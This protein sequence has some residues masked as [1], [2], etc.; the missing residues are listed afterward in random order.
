MSRSLVS[1]LAGTF[2]LRLSTGLTGLLLVNYLASLH[3]FGGVQVTSREVS[4]VAILFFATELVLSPAFGILCDR[5]GRKP[6]MQS[7]PIFGAAAVIITGLSAY[8]PVLL[9][10]RVL[11]GASTAASVPAILGFVAVATA[12]DEGLRGRAVAGFE[13]ATIGGLGAGGVLAGPMWDHLG[14]VAFFLNAGIYGVSFL[15]YTFGIHEA[16]ARP[17]PAASGLLSPVQLVAKAGRTLVNGIASSVRRYRHLLS[18]SHV[19]LLAPTWIALNAAIGV[20]SI[21]TVFQLVGGGAG[22]PFAAD[23]LFMQGF[24]ATQVSMGFGVGFTVFI[25]GMLFWGNQFK[26]YRRTSIIAFGAA[27][28]GVGIIDLFLLNHAFDVAP[29]AFGAGI[30]F[31]GLALFVL[32]GATPAALGLLA[33]VSEAYPHDR[34]AIMGLY[35]V[36]LGIGQIVGNA[37]AGYAADFRGIDGL[38]GLTFLLLLVALVPLYSLRRYEHSVGGR[39][40][41][42]VPHPPEASL[43]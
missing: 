37:L 29:I 38:L 43:D 2:T 39:T 9:G 33:D 27:A 23:Q 5:I 24:T 20:F 22:R 36:F 17:V 4:L 14:P 18:R 32:A 40:P 31:A 7:G 1:V 25:A 8:V 13:V 10:T 15:I 11:E 12:H 30:A 19:M 42:V 6:V 28:A 41:A 21:Q 35:S 26:R 16:G 34:G 3:L